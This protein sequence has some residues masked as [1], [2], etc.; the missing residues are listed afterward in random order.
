MDTTTFLSNAISDLAWPMVSLVVIYLFKTDIASKIR[1][2]KTAEMAGAKITFAEVAESVVTQL[3]I[4]VDVRRLLSFREK[5]VA[6]LVLTGMNNDQI[7]EALGISR[8][9]VEVH[10]AKIL[11]ITGTNTTDELRAVFSH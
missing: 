10:R 2:A 4:A 9:T 1:S 8:K 7:A 11:E 6:V 5:Q 3:P